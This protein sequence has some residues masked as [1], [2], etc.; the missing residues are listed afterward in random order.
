[1][2]LRHLTSIAWS[3]EIMGGW[4]D[5]SL[6]KAVEVAEARRPSGPSPQR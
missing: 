3:V 1:M 2:T 4:Q 6:L 5:Y